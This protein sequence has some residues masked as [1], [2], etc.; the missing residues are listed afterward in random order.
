MTLFVILCIYYQIRPS[1]LIL[2]LPMLVFPIICLSLGF[3]FILSLLN[4]I[5][6]DIGNA[7]SILMTFF[8]F[9]TP[10]LYARPATGMLAH[11]TNYNML[12]YLVCV[13]R[14]IILMGIM[15]SRPDWIG[16]FI[17]VILSF[18]IFVVCLVIFHLTETRVAERI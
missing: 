2:F 18:A 11:L 4:G 14:N 6:R 15:N 13:P 10:V 17:S 5:F 8:M 16:V 3:G 12:Y 9:L 7:L 1:I